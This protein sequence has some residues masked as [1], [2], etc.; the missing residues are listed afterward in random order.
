MK[1]YIRPA[2]VESIIY[3]RA[4]KIMTQGQDVAEKTQL[5]K[6]LRFIVYG[7]AWLFRGSSRSAA[8]IEDVIEG[9]GDDEGAKA[10]DDLLQ[11]NLNEQGEIETYID[12]LKQIVAEYQHTADFP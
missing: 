4:K 2:F 8:L 12:L 6:E 5:P 9:H 3:Q 7:Y 11:R 10:D 1:L